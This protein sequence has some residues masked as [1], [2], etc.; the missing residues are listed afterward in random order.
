[1]G[2]HPRNLEDST[3][4]RA[5]EPLLKDTEPAC[6]EPVVPNRRSLLMATKSS[7]HSLE[8]EKACTQQQRPSKARKILIFKNASK[9]VEKLNHLCISEWLPWSMGSQRVGHN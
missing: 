9:V 6:L 8:L 7:T 4:H 3:R 1:M 5:A 2:W